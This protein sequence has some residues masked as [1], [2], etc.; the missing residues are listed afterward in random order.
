MRSQIPFFVAAV[1]RAAYTISFGFSTSC[2]SLYQIEHIIN[3][4]MRS[5]YYVL[6]YLKT[7]QS[8]IITYR[9]NYQHLKMLLGLHC[10]TIGEIEKDRRTHSF[11]LRFGVFM[12]QRLFQILYVFV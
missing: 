10:I 3:D 12:V 7:F 9:W 6:Y 8:H 1:R 4:F 5:L 11:T 2:I